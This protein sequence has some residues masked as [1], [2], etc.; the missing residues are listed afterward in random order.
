MRSNRIHQALAKEMTLRP[1]DHRIR[2]IVKYRQQIAKARAVESARLPEPP[3]RVLTVVPAVA[4]AAGPSEIETL[5][6]EPDVDK[7]WLDLKVYACL[8][9]STSVIRA[10]RVWEEGHT[11][12]GVGIGI[13]DTGID[14]EHPDFAGR[15]AGVA[16]FTGEGIADTNGH[17]THVA[18]IVSGDGRAS[19]GKYRGVAPGSHL[20]V[21]KVLDR[22]G[23][24]F[25]SDV[26]A[27]IEWA[28]QQKVHV[29]NL[30]LSGP[31]PGDGTDALSETC[32]LVV[33]R[34]FVVC[35]AAGNSGPTPGGIGPPGCARQVITVGASTDEDTI[36]EASSRG[37]TAD[38]RVKPDV[39]FPGASIVSCRASNASL[40]NALNQGYTEASGTSMATPHASGVTALLL[41][42]DPGL[43]PREIKQLIM[44]SAVDLGL[45]ENSQ[46]AGRG[47]AYASLGS[48]PIPQVGPAKPGCLLQSAPLVTLLGRVWARAHRDPR[49]DLC[50]LG[51]RSCDTIRTLWG[52]VTR[53]GEGERTVESRACWR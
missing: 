22:Q 38:G 14:L 9:V 49:W 53:D 2:I 10:P 39:L 50:G 44:G 51:E 29:M 32:D 48:V 18:G 33:E 4:L 37:P 41:E 23:S 27:G 26:M 30:S 7:I 12:A 42:A 11:G 13:L 35:G 34:G 6:H 1:S 17:G 36:L 19:D 28:V 20:Y 24:A 47:D 25:M 31:A 5:S 8:D 21:A 3:S 43:T 16:D 46:G 15:I 52:T 40:G 45:E